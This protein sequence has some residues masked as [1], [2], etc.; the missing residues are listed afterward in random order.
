MNPKNQPA[1][2]TTQQAFHAMLARHALE[3]EPRP[4][5]DLAMHS[6][7][8]L[9]PDA[10]PGQRNYEVIFFLKYGLDPIQAF[11]GKHWDNFPA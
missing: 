2:Q 3:S 5:F 8:C 4:I 6:I 11:D 10:M 9:N 1:S 7:N